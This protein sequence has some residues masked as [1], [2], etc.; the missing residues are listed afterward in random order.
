MKAKKRIL[1]APLDWGIGHATRCIPIIQQLITHNYEVIIAS[2]YL[3]NLTDN[4]N[5]TCINVDD[6]TWSANNWTVANSNIDP[7]HYFSNNCSTVPFDCTDSLEVTDVI[8]DNANLTMNIAI[9]NGYN[10]FLNYPYVA[11]TIDANGDTIQSG[12]MNLFVA[13][14]LDTAWYNYSLSS[15]I[16]P[17][18]PLTIYFVYSDGSLVTDTC[19]LTYNS[20]PT[21]I[22]DINSIDERKLIR[23]TDV[24]GR[25]TKG[26]RNKPLLYIYN[27]GRVEKRI[28]IE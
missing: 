17:T 10:Y 2:S 9:Y 14:S 16:S 28:V 18:Y 8:I 22:T 13:F 11:F 3:F 23:I 25:E 21:A 4:A 12:N 20:I 26:T 19:I 5:L 6:S 7:Q 24:L 1:V 27:D 15:L